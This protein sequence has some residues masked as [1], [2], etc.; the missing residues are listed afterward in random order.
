VNA[1]AEKQRAL[2][3]LMIAG[4]ALQKAVEA[5]SRVTFYRPI[6]KTEAIKRIMAAGPNPL[7]EKAH[8][9]SSAETFVEQDALYAAAHAEVTKAVT[10]RIQMEHEYA[11]AKFEAEYAVGVAVRQ[12]EPIGAGV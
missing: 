4:Y 5:E 9:A 8:S 11:I 10:W 6:A 12:H 3:A 2:S 1:V 7:T